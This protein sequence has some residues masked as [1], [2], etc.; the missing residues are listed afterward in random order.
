MPVYLWIALGTGA[1]PRAIL[2]LTR[3]RIDFANRL[4]EF[5]PHGRAQTKKRRARVPIA[6]SLLPVLQDTVTATLGRKIGNLVT[7]A[8][9]P[10]VHIRM[11]FRHT[12]DR[13]IRAEARN[14]LRLWRDSHRGEAREALADAR[15]RIGRLRVVSPYVLRHTFAT[16]L[17]RRD[18]PLDDIAAFL[19]HTPRL[20]ITAMYAKRGPENVARALTAIDLYLSELRTLVDASGAEHAEGTMCGRFAVDDDPSEIV[21]PLGELVELI[22]IEPT[23]S[24]LRSRKSRRLFKRIPP[25]RSAFVRKVVQRV[26]R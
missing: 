5:N 13:A 6:T 9:K 18:V 8:G 4:I 24:S 17:Y 22:G 15:R 16:E 12:A 1:R 3:D 23:T 19:G 20:R 14:A 26:R 21:K 11:A 7:Y 10:V 2:E 25:Q